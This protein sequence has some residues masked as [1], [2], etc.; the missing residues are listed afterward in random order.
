MP[1]VT[2]AAAA[3]AQA[4]GDDDSSRTQPEYFVRHLPTGALSLGVRVAASL[5]SLRLSLARPVVTRVL[6]WTYMAEAE[7]AATTAVVKGGDTRRRMASVVD[8]VSRLDGTFETLKM[9]A[10]ALTLVAC[11]TALK[12]G[13]NKKA[14]MQESARKRDKAAKLQRENYPALADAIDLVVEAMPTSDAAFY[15]KVTGRHSTLFRA[16][17][18][19]L[20]PVPRT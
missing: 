3:A 9:R 5:V 1:A 15:D 20:P 11:A 17:D 14:F 12:L 2:R 10:K 6:T 13:D 18:G 8:A 16:P 19:R 7:D 4:G